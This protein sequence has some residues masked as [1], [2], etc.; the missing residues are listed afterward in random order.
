MD[1]RVLGKR[2]VATIVT[3]LFILLNGSACIAGDGDTEQLLIGMVEQFE[4]VADYTCRLDKRVKKNG[5]LYE[6]L[7]IS[8][9]YKKPQQYY[10][11]WEQGSA[12]G[13]EVIFVA[14]KNND[15]L[16]AHPGGLFQFVTL[17]LNPDG[18]LAMQKNRHSLRHSGME[19]IMSLIDS[20][21]KR[22][23]EIGL[24]AIQNVEEGRM[25][26]KGLLSVECTFPENHGF[27]AHRIVIGIDKA[28]NLLVRISIFDWSEALVEEYLFRD[29]KVNVGL[30][31]I[32]FHPGNP[33]YR[34]YNAK[35]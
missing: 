34:F 21:Y 1:A 13:R 15:R 35:Q 28:L 22:S 4:K 31:E 17:R 2:Y 16:V 10:F 23:Q 14:G 25:D 12:K 29:L 19:K 18:H 6:D 3:S 24:D 27:Y 33:E 8:V 11:R 7:A 20:N 30:T 32:D 26:G 5:I 9:K